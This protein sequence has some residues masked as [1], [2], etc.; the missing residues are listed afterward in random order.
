MIEQTKDDIKLSKWPYIILNSMIII[1][2]YLILLMI[3]LTSTLFFIKYRIDFLRNNFFYVPLLFIVTII[4][5][6]CINKKF[7]DKIYNTNFYKKIKKI[8]YILVILFFVY[9]VGYTISELNF[10]NRFYCNGGNFENCKTGLD[11]LFEATPISLFSI[12]ALILI[13]FISKLIVKL[14]INNGDNQNKI[15]VKKYIKLLI[16]FVVVSCVIGILRFVHYQITPLRCYGNSPTTCLD[17][18]NKYISSYFDGTIGDKGYYYYN[19]ISKKIHYFYTWPQDLDF[20]SGKFNFNK[21]DDVILLNKKFFVHEKN[22]K[23][24]VDTNSKEVV[25]KNVKNTK[26]NG[27]FNINND[28]YYLYND[29][30]MV[31]YETKSNR[32][33]I[34]EINIDYYGDNYYVINNDDEYNPLFIYNT[35]SKKTIGAVKNDS[36]YKKYF[37]KNII[38][39]LINKEIKINASFYNSDEKYPNIKIINNKYYFNDD[40]KYQELEMQYYD[41]KYLY[42][43]LKKVN[44]NMYLIYNYKDNSIMI[45]DVKI[46][47]TNKTDANYRIV[48][49]GYIKND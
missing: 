15:L 33:F 39:K 27:I 43:P 21:Y 8:S 45:N 18:F 5:D 29:F 30:Y 40:D 1:F 44:S 36:D 16:A 28:Y 12:L 31:V 46:Y 14:N 48:D 9:I 42:F 17:R 22:D 32:Y 35:E 6:Y 49:I 3:Y 34:K 23:I 20:N 13:I 25:K 38:N 24:I 10:M 19:P 7:R 26:I 47:Y 11:R 37:D 2:L 4:L 41:D